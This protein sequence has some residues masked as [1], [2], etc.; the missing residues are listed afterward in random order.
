MLTGYLGP[1]SKQD[2][3]KMYWT[4]DPPSLTSRQRL[5][6]GIKGSIGDN[7]SPGL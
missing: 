5:C 4:M 2:T 6:D 1:K 3:P 7:K